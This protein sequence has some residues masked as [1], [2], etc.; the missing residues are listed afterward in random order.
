MVIKKSVNRISDWRSLGVCSSSSR[1][2]LLFLDLQ[3]NVFI[4]NVATASAGSA[5]VV[6]FVDSIAT[7]AEEFLYFLQFFPA[8]R[9]KLLIIKE[10]FSPMIWTHFR[11]RSESVDL[12]TP[13][14]PPRTR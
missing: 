2:S 9:A 3:T 7:G 5:V 13:Y 8:H 4:R 1:E 12:P 14:S 6:A 11:H 10:Q